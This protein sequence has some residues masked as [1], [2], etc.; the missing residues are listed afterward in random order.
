MYTHYP[1]TTIQYIHPINWSCSPSIAAANEGNNSLTHSLT[2]FPHEFAKNMRSNVVT[3][4]AFLCASN[5]DR[6]GNE[7]YRGIAMTD[8]Q[9]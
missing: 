2:A 7:E 5:R 1:T 9:C 8:A 6:K 4:S 3:T